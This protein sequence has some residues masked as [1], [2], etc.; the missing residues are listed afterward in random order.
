MNIVAFKS[1][2]SGIGR[3]IGSSKIKY[4]WNLMVRNELFKVELLFSKISKTHR[5]LI[6]DNMICEE[7]VPHSHFYFKLAVD[8]IILEICK[9]PKGEYELLIN[10]QNY[11]KLALTTSGNSPISSSRDLLK[12]VQQSTRFKIEKEGNYFRLSRQP[13]SSNTIANAYPS[14]TSIDNGVKNVTKNGI[15]STP[16]I[17]SIKMLDDSGDLYKHDFYYLYTKETNE[18]RD[19]I[20]YVNNVT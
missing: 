7:K 3:L 15:N 13:V 20:N 12:N 18:D 14:N 19:I 5:I 2:K 9:N 8:D 4:E 10:G 11:E 17:G 6:N 16:S 1:N